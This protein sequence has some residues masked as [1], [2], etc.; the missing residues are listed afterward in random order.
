[1]LPGV[2]GTPRGPEGIRSDAKGPRREVRERCRAPSRNVFAE[3]PSP[4]VGLALALLATL[5]GARPATAQT[6]LTPGD[7]RL[8]RTIDGSDSLQD[9][10]IACLVEHVAQGLAISFA[11]EACA[12]AAEE[13]L[14]LG[15]DGPFDLPAGGGGASFDPAAIAASCSNPDPRRSQT[16]FDGMSSYDVYRYMEHA[17][18]RRTAAAEAGNK[19]A[20]EYW[21]D[22]ANRAFEELETRCEGKDIES[23]TALPNVRPGPEGVGSCEETLATTREVLRECARTDYAG[24]CAE[25]GARLRGCP[26]PLYAYVEPGQGLACEDEVDPEALQ[27]AWQERCEQL[28]TPGPDGGSPCSPPKSPSAASRAAPSATCATTLGPS[29]APTATCAWSRSRCV[30][31]R[32]P[33]GPTSRR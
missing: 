27:R 10:A 25:L 12:L 1:M 16:S 8:L 3:L 14:A 26:N 17:K 18:D 30:R 11:I 23:C 13:A 32:G 9:L 2:G 24:P 15:A 21:N 6:L 22:E 5:A 29:S 33:R 7:P 4:R 31:R 28:T 19:K 20:E